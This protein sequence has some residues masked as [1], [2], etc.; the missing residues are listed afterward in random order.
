MSTLTRREFLRVSTVAAAATL[1]AACAVPAE[2]TP[3]PEAPTTAPAAPEAPTT[4]PAA[5]ETRFQ[6][7]PMLAELVQAGELPSVDERLPSN[8][9]VCPVMEMTGKFG[10]TIRRGFKGVSDRWGPTKMQNEGLTWYNDDLT[11][12]VNL[13]ES[14]EANEDASMWTC[15]MREGLKWS[16]GTPLT[17][18]DVQWY[19]DYRVTNEDITPTIPSDWST[20]TPRIL[21]ELDVT[22]D[23]TFSLTYADPK[24]LW[25]FDVTRDRPFVPGHYMQQ[26]HP[27]FVDQ[28]ELDAAAQEAGMETWSDMFTDREYWYNDPMRPTV[29]PWVSMNELSSE[30]FLMERNPYFWQVD[31]DGKQLPYVDKV[32]HR[33]FETP[34][35]FNLWIVNG[36]IDFQARH[37]GIGN[38]T[39]FKESEESGEYQVF[40]GVSAGHL[41]I[42][43]N[44]TTKDARLRELFQDRNVRLAVSHAVNR[45]EI[46]ELVFDGLAKPRQYSPLEQSPQYYPALSD[47]HLEYDPDTANQLLDEAGYAERDADGFRL[48]KD[49]SGDTISFTMEG[50]APPGDPDEDA[51]Q[52]IVR[53]LADVGLKMAYRYA[54]RSL[55][56]EHYSANEIEAAWWGGDR[57]VLPIVAPWIFTGTMIDRPWGVAWGL[58]HDSPD[59]PN[60]E[61][62]P[63]GHWIWDIWDNWD[64]MLVEP[65]DAKRE[66]IFRNILD[67]WVEELPQ[68]GILGQIPS[69]IIVKNGMRNYLPG[70]PIDDTT[71]DE[72]LLNTQTY[73]WEDPEMHM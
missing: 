19:W 53:Y 48:F 46:N 54:E 23:F 56:E 70:Y 55:Y 18:A 49:G 50:T 57:T 63:E 41:C 24:P 29:G 22:D 60:A 44:Q 39:L 15:H 33:L 58:Y 61:E 52:V 9:M 45:D 69:P 34:D 38:Y 35:V 6:E 59:D 66:E 28:A 25:P 26:Y 1:T 12:R 31:A 7:A 51:A 10:G 64:K 32:N 36:E 14:Y 11:V 37:V 71:E 67:I 17:T 47:A 40:L 13:L 42:Q 65:D 5:P 16:D 62:P 2:P 72:H 73:F 3:A 20:G 68:V 21:A 8:P 4:A 43:L 30:L 27:D